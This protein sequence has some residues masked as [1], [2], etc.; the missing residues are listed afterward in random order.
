MKCRHFSQTALVLLAAGALSARAQVS[1]GGRTGGRSTISFNPDVSVIID[2]IFY[3]HGGHEPLSHVLEELRGFGHVHGNDDHG[4]DHDHGFEPGFNLRHLELMLQADVDP[5]FKGWAIVGVE[6]DGAELEEAV[7]LTTALPF[8]LQVKL[9]KFFSD[10]SRLN[11]QHAHEWNFTDAPLIQQ[12]LFGDH[13]LNEK[14]V[15]VSWLA[16]TPFYLNLGIEVLQGEN[17]AA[18]V[19]HGDGPLPERDGPRAGV[20]WLKAAPNLYG[21]HAV[22][23]GLF[24]AHGIHQEEHLGAEGH[25]DVS[26]H[27]LDG[28]QTFWGADVVYRYTPPRA[29][30]HGAFTIEGGYIGRRKDVELVAHNNP[31]RAGLLGRSL[32]EE[33][34][35]LYLQA[36]YGFAPRWRTGIRG[37]MLGLTNRRTRPS[38]ASEAFDESYRGSAMIDWTLTEFSRLRLQCSF[39]RYDTDEGKEDVAEVFL[40][41]VFSLGAHGAHRF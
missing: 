13:G 41:A 14:G 24:A 34:D 17:E 12:A 36:L 26:S 29:Y 37:E 27:Y 40:Q 21:P 20:G 23:F 32:V 22:Q 3:A 2:T 7:I 15:Q 28:H 16:P 35:G 11:A 4:H 33:Q 5:Y 9:G 38:G 39:G 6:P 30:G 25:A 1:G 8:G 18:F 10:Y 19:Y 31:E